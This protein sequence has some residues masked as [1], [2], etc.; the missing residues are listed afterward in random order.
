MKTK[1]LLIAAATLAVGAVTSQAQVYS[2]N[3]VGYVNQTINGSGALNLIANPLNATTN[4]VETVLPAMQ[5]GEIVYAWNGGGFYVYQYYPGLSTNGYASDW[6][7]YSGGNN[8]PGDVLDSDSGN[9]FAPQPLIKPGQAIF[10]QNPN[11]T[12]TNTYAGTVV[13]STTNAPITLSGSGQL[14]FIASAAPLAG[15]LETNSTINLPLQGGEIIYLW[16]GGGYYVYQYYPGLY[17]TYPSDWVDYSGGNN[18]PGDVL[19]SDSGNWFAPNPNI[20]VGQGFFYQNPNGATNWTQ[21][22]HLN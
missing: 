22:V 21:N 15:D 16:N 7:D 11:G 2:Q 6:V 12:Y 20:K 17:P 9:W 19:D 13:L 1:T 18:I 8:I 3:V 14:S 5:G 10:L 4:L